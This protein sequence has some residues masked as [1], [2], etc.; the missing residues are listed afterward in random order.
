MKLLGIHARSLK[1]LR[2][3]LPQST[4]RKPFS[5]LSINVSS[6]LS[7]S[8]LEILDL[9]HWSPKIADITS[10]LGPGRPA[11]T[12]QHLIIDH[13]TE[14]PLSDGDGFDDDEEVGPDYDWDNPPPR[15][16]TNSW[17]APGAHLVARE[18]PLR[19]L[20]AALH[21]TR[22]SFAPV[23]CRLALASL[24]KL[25]RDG[26]GENTAALDGLRVANWVRGKGAGRQ[27]QGGG[28]LVPACSRVRA[29]RVSG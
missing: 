11:P 7:L 17:P 3:S 6:F 23:G 10:L 25:L 21:D 20:S 15:I 9:T 27:R 8:A 22:Y 26:A 12:L 4:S 13:G 18:P 28:R 29:F 19:S 14:L 2:I 1:R 16:E 24:R 5:A